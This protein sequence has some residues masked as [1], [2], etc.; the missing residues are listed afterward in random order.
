MLYKVFDK[1]INLKEGKSI[2][3]LKIINIWAAD[4]AKMGSLYSK[5]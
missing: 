3:G 2:Q 1:K 4:L 5:N